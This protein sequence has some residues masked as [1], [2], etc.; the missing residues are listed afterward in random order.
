LQETK[1]KPEQLTDDILEPDGWHA[2]WHSA[3][4]P[5]Y[6]SVA[7]MSKAKPDE[8]TVGIGDDQ[9]DNEGR[10]MAVRFGT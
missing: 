8:V 7:I 3:E 5:G 1:A 6:S 2:F 4:K 10:V 9:F